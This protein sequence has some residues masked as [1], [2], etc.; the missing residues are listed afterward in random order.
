MRPATPSL[1]H[2]AKRPSFRVSLRRERIAARENLASQE[3]AT[4]SRRVESHLW[5]L[6]ATRPPD[7]I[8]FCWPFRAEFDARPLILR[9]LALGWRAGLPVL[10]G[11]AQPMHFRAWTPAASL[12]IDRYGIHY[13][14]D[15]Q[16]MLPD[17]L[18]LPVNAFDSAGYRLG[19]GG[20]YFD[21]TLAAMAPSPLTIGVG[22]ELA[23]VDSIHPAPHDIALD[24]V[25]TELGVETYSN[26]LVLS[27]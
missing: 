13:P 3:H 10:N 14:T 1:E 20:G 6:L 9:L 2:D 19:Y 18:L 22:F 8:G 24:A 5:A 17:L 23:R 11:V 16:P 15:D 4:L 7:A 12:S 26:G 21:R 25:I 27:P